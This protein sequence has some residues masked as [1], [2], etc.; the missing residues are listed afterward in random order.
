MGLVD[1]P[2]DDEEDDDDETTSPAKRMRLN[3]SQQ[4]FKP[5]R[6]QQAVFRSGPWSFLYWSIRSPLMIDLILCDGPFDQAD[7]DSTDI[8]GRFDPC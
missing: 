4:Q 5:K 2:D 8:D 1:Y 6:N 3:S 7:P